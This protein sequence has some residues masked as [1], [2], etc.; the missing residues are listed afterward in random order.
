MAGVI[1]NSDVKIGRGC[2]INTASSIDHDC[3]VGD[4]VHVSVGA[5]VA[6]TYKIGNESWLGAGAVVS[7]RGELH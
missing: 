5:H 3:V 4:F 1:V 2:I 6:G 7:K